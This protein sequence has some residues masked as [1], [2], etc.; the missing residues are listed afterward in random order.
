MPILEVLPPIEEIWVSIVKGMTL[1]EIFESQ[2]SLNYVVNSIP[3]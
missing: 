1:F 3:I 2:P